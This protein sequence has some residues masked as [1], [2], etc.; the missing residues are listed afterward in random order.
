MRAPYRN[1]DLEDGIE[2]EE[3]DRKPGPSKELLALFMQD[4]MNKEKGKVAPDTTGADYFFLEEFITRDMELDFA[5][6]E[7]DF[8]KHCSGRLQE[9]HD[10]GWYG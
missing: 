7:Q 9:F 2:L 10:A 1:L 6:I 4:L 8:L 3:I 5:V